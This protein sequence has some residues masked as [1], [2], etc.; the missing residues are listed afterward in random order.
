M[1]F[2]KY[3]AQAL[4]RDEFSRCFEPQPTVKPRNF[5]LYWLY[6]VGI[7]IRYGILLPI[8]LTV[9]VVATIIFVSMLPV[10]F[11]VRNINLIRFLY[12]RY[13]Q[14]W[15]F[16][17]GAIIRHHGCKPALHEAHIFVANHTSF[18]DYFLTSS[19]DFPHAT[20]A[21]THGGLFG[22]F[23]KHALALN[24][25]LFF[26]RNEHR[27]RLKVAKKMQTHIDQRPQLAPLIIFPEGTC[28]NNES[29]VLF[30]KGAFELSALVCPV[31]IKYDKRLLDPYWNTREQTFTQH[32]FYLMTRWLMV[33][34]VWWLPP[35]RRHPDETAIQFAERVK[36]LIS[37]AAG[38]KNLSW[39]GY[40]KNCMRDADQEKMR[41]SSQEQYGS[42]LKRRLT[43]APP[44]PNG[45]CKSIDRAD[46][47]VSFKK[48]SNSLIGFE[49]MCRSSLEG[50]R[51]SQFFFPDWLS[52][53]SMIN[54]QNE[55]LIHNSQSAQNFSLNCIQHIR[56]RANDAVQTWRLYSR[57][58]R[59]S[60]IL[61][62]QTIDRR[63][64]NSSWRLWSK[65]RIQ[66]RSGSTEVEEKSESG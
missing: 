24:G 2:L 34:D 6:L 17:F 66:E 9:L 18:T 29:T 53:G 14:A 19:Q 43:P 12:R 54:I 5:V 26:N 64:E 65:Q 27:D 13:C 61:G 39:D 22:W 32:V 15:L 7:G 41:K 31:A 59:Q 20:V 46:T 30:H 36:A 1:M 57:I 37:N 33:A 25:S 40:M 38:L 47:D 62:A 44:T 8:R 35:Q 10:V 60:P 58:N 4:S 42:S 49:E 21:Q 55:L 23:Q 3:A 56:E 28:V 51:R 52:E 50:T 16:S 48:R 63:I 45:I 11:I